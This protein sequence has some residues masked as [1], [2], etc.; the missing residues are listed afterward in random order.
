[1]VD[2]KKNFDGSYFAAAHRKGNR[3]MKIYIPVIAAIAIALGAVF[4]MGAQ[5]G[6]MPGAKM[7]L[8]THPHKMWEST[9]PYGRITP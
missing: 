3:Y 6:V 1:M 7:V 5:G 8:H 9:Y 4:I 2:K